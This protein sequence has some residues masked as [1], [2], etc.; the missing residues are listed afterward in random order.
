MFKNSLVIC[1]L[2]IVSTVNFTISVAFA[3]SKESEQQNF[4]SYKADLIQIE[5]YLNNISH[6]S[7]DFIQELDNQKTVG[8]FYLS[9]NGK[10]AGKMRIEYL[11]KPKILVVVNGAVLHY[12]DIELDQLLDI[13]S[14]ATDRANFENRAIDYTKRTSINFIG[15]RKEKNPEKKTHFWLASPAATTAM[16]S[17]FESRAPATKPAPFTL[18]LNHR[19][20]ELDKTHHSGAFIDFSLLAETAYAFDDYRKLVK[21]F[22]SIFVTNVPIFDSANRDACRRFMAFIDIVYD[23]G[24]ELCMSAYAF[25]HELYQDPDNKL[26]FARTASRLGEML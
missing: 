6:L 3:N 15:V 4:S 23:S 25:P 8:K 2:F 11:D 18:Q 19:T 9:R 20:W 10:K 17:A 7:S 22:P 26:P 1:L 13:T 12:Q 16:E 24:A 14:S 21:A 5:N